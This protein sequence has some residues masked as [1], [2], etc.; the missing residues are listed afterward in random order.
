LNHYG[1]NTKPAYSLRAGTMQC[2]REGREK[3][4]KSTK[5]RKKARKERQAGCT[6]SI[7]AACRVVCL[8]E[9]F[10]LPVTGNRGGSR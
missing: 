10:E 7:R 6:E 2:R 1:E 5:E 3:G 8:R 4:R 9:C